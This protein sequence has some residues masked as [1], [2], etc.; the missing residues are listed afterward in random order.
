MRAC[1]CTD[2]RVGSRERV[3]LTRVKH[4]FNRSSFLPLGSNIVHAHLLAKNKL[5]AQVA[6]L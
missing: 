3:E 2:A 4:F 1:L 6:L 5:W